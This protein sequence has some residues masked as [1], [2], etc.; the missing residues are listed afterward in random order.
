MMGNV[1]KVKNGLVEAGQKAFGFA[2]VLEV[3]GAE[4]G[5]QGGLFDVDAIE[6]SSSGGD[7]GYRKAEPVAGVQTGGYKY[8]QQSQV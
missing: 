7:H 1:V 8:Q 4:G 3:G 5:S 6:D 2:G